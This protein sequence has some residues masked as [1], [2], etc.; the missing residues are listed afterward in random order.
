LAAEAAAASDDPA[1]AGPA[2]EALVEA[3]PEELRPT[4]EEVVA[5]A[6]NGPGDPAFDEPYGQMI[7]FVR[8]NCGFS[9]LAVTGTE[10]SFDGLA[11]ELAAGPTIVDFENAGNE[12]H[13]VIF[14]RINDD[15]TETVEEILALPEE[16]AME[17]ATFQAIAF[18]FPGSSGTT[19]TD[20]TPGRYAALCFLPVGAAPEVIEQMEGPDSTPPPGVELGPP[21]F[22]MGMVHEFTV[23]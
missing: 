12:V 10:Y 5:N 19:V 2:F 11:A 7:D 16:E 20:F 13:E 4:V 18:A 22:T 9:E 1:S 21:H 8:E 17:K 23:S 6:E 3:A 14:L 15:T